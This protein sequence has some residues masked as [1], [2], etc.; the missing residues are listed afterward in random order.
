MSDRTSLRRHLSERFANKR[1]RN[2]YRRSF[3]FQTLSA[4]LRAMREDRGWTQKMLAD[5]ANMRQSRISG[6]ENLEDSAP[7]LTTLDRIAEAFDVGIEFRFV[8]Y[9]RIVDRAVTIERDDLRIPSYDEDDGF[10]ER[11][12]CW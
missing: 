7:T 10:R 9:S 1:Y 3:M 2:Q 12:V 11:L 5:A 8:P 6:L 4:Q